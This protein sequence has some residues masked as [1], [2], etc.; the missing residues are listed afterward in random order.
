MKLASFFI[1]LVLLSVP[2]TLACVYG[3][4]VAW[5][6]TG[7]LSLAALNSLTEAITDYRKA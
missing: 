4:A 1:V 5:F 2:L 6:F 3:S 7:W